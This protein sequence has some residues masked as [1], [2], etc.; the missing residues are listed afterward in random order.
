MGVSQSVIPAEWLMQ[1]ILECTLKL[2]IRK[3]FN[4]DNTHIQ[5]KKIETLRGSY[6]KTMLGRIIF[7]EET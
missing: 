3:S 5:A 7:Q 1:F 2:E 4:D 6:R